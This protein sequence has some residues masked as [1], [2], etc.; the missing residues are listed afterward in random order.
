METKSCVVLRNG[1]EIKL[2]VGFRFRPTDE[3]L[4]LHYLK[5]K[6]LSASLPALFI[7]EL[8]VFE[9]DPWSLPGV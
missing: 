7:P 6:V 2:P 9:T 4:L 3:E 1:G 5:R 8:D